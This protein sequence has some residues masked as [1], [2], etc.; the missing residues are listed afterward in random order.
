MREGKRPA[1][2]TRDV[3]VRTVGDE[4]LVYDLARHRAH[5]LNPVATAV[6]RAWDGA[7]DVPARAAA[8]T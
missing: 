5:S 1:A 7:R 3:V 2:R 4:V 6:W 8:E